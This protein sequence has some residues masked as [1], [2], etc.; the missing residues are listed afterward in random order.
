MGINEKSPTIDK[1]SGEQVRPWVRYWARM[2]DMLL[3]S[4]IIGVLFALILIITGIDLSYI[5][6]FPDFLFGIF[7]M[8]LNL[9]FEPLLLSTW[10]TT[11][12]KFLLKVKVR[13]RDGSKL[14]YKDGFIRTATLWFRGL[15]LS[16]PF[17]SL[18]T[19]AVAHGRLVDNHETSWDRDGDFVV[20]HQ[21]IGLLRVFVV[22]LPMVLILYFIIFPTL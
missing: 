19:L 8:F 21:R 3:F 7:I 20:S 12:G 22:M 16:I 17:V 14:S 18:V 10:G 5:L 11:L 9:F 6:E 2:F 13:N 4:L 1:F 15:G